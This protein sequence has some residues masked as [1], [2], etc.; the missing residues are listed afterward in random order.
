MTMTEDKLRDYLKRTAA[1]LQQTRQQLREAQ[2]GQTEPI[3]IIG[4]SCRYPGGVSSPD[5]LWDLVSAGRDAVGEFPVDRGWDVERLYDPDP[6]PGKTYVRQGGF[7]HDAAGFDAEFFG[8]SPNDARRADPQQRILLE[9]SWEAVEQSGIDP[10]SLHGSAT[11]VYAGLMYHDYNL[12]SPGGSLASG[13]VAYSLGLE[14]PAVTLDTACSSSLVAIH[15]AGQALRRGEVTL[16]LAG[17]VTV[18]GTPDMFVD[19]S[20]LRGLAPDGRCKAFSAGA[21]GTGWSEG[22]GVLVLQRLS[23]ARRAGRRVLAV[24]RGSAVNQDGASNGF[25]APNGPAQVRVIERALADAGLTPSDVDAVDGHG[26]GTSLGDPIEAQALITAYG[27]RPPDCPLWL[28][29]IKSNLSHPQAAAGVAGVIKMVQAMRH[30][31]LPKTLH[32]TEPSPHVDWSAGTVRLLTQ[33]RDWPESGRPRRAAVSSFGISG[34]NAHVI[35]EEGESQA[36]DPV[37]SGPAVTALLLSAKSAAALAQAAARLSDHLIAYPDVSLPDI[38][39]SLATS[40]SALECR[41]A[42]WGGDRDGVLAGLRSLAGGEPHPGVVTG[43]ADLRGKTAFLFAGDDAQW[44]ESTV[45]LL[46][47]SPAFAERIGECERALSPFV[48]WSVS[49]VLRGDPHAPPAGRA[50]VAQP[51]M[52]AVLVSLAAVW[53]SLGVRPDVVGGDLLGEIAAACVA[54][55]LSLQDGAL[56][57]L[58]RRLPATD[59]RPDGRLRLLP[60]VTGDW[61]PVIGDLADQGYAVFVEISPHP[62]LVA[63]ISE[64]LARAGHDLVA[65]GTLSRDASGLSA[66]A[67]ALFARGVSMDWPAFF[68]GGRLVDLPTYPFQHQRYW[69]DPVPGTSKSTVDAW[70]YRVRWRQLPDIQPAAALT[71]VWLVAARDGAERADA[72]S[73]ALV[74]AGVTVVR[75]DPVGADRCALAE[76]IRGE[77]G[78]LT[79]A[80]VLTLADDAAATVTLLQAVRDAGS[81]AP[82]WCLTDQAVAVDSVE[83]VDPDAS[84]VWGLGVVLGLDQPG[85]WGG[86]IDLT[87]AGDEPAMTRLCAVLAGADGE[88][89]VAIRP[90]GVF[91]RRLVRAPRVAEG[92]GTQWRPRG[93]VLVTGG[94][95]AIGSRVARWLAGAGADHIVLAS[96]SGAGAPGAAELASELGARVTIVPCDVGDAAQV[97]GLLAAMPAPLTAVVHAAGVMTDETPLPDMTLAEFAAANRPK[98]AGAT[99]LDRLLGDRALDAFVLF[100][101]G[102]AVWGGA[103]RPAYAAANAY[104]DGL[105]QR[106]RARGLAATSIAWGTWAGGGMADV[107]AS[108]HLRRL[109]LSGMDPDVAILALQQALEDGESH[110]V[111]A[112]IDWSRFAPVYELAR[113]RPLLRELPEAAAVPPARD[114]GVA[115][116]AFAARLVGLTTTERSRELLRLVRTEVATV[117]GH[118]DPRTVE[119]VRAFTELGF[120]SVSAVDLAGRLTRAT[121][122]ALPATAVFDYA[123]PKALAGFL[124]AEL[125]S[126][127]ESALSELNRLE[128]LVSSLSREEIERG[129]VIDRLRAMVTKLDDSQRVSAGSAITGLLDGAT[130]EDVFD[131]LDKEL[132]PNATRG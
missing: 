27:R 91:A 84:A 81:T 132:G 50:D 32:V 48:D 120:D 65:V 53:A 75:V 98:V 22:V 18:M 100:S 110:L 43:R 6:Q 109:G 115:G 97:A 20:R 55:V 82:F 77:V 45:Q 24:I 9:A 80:G 39:F 47:D 63:Q 51:V 93:T 122:I 74:A 78:G 57:A 61:A 103:G 62:V 1:E 59:P 113:R 130:A 121:G 111:V 90:A 79:L 11:G 35:L 89:Q 112:D 40:R 23:E 114:E 42:V 131:L 86:L 56:A 102:A 70:R 33:A 105:A 5:D 58:G 72:I 108:T 106:R 12:G 101:S 16:A 19:F 28:G 10:Q 96:R 34:T 107:A 44:A 116:G 41:A 87:G 54:D 128:T 104:L 31:T 38:G 67:A 49:G 69:T 117:L 4:M 29:S 60:V 17:G 37:T 36:P 21:D 52:W 68:C 25:T 123:S 26:T 118:Q 129:N 94:T 83:D 13:Q 8:I 119:P 73:A 64:T 46:A 3:A 66:A 124:E 92:S 88:D 99:H 126:S 7:L 76:R 71:G 2:T 85:T 125:G 95:G 127:G 30:G 14:G 15:L